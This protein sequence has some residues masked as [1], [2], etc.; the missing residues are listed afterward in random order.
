[1]GVR[2]MTLT[3]NFDNEIGS[4]NLNP[5]LKMRMRQ[6]MDAWKRMPGQEET[7][8]GKQEEGILESE[9]RGGAQEA[10]DAFYHT[11]NVTKGLTEKGG[12]GHDSRCLPFIRSGVLGR[13]GNDEKTFCGKSFQCQSGLSLCEE[14]DR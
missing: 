14:Y 10:F 12:T 1:M 6:A 8:G 7:S 3:W 5:E 2:M 13:A 11:P 9:R 4:P